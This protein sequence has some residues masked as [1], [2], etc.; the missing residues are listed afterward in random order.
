MS[1][2]FTSLLRLP[3]DI[4]LTRGLQFVEL[5]GSAL[6]RI[7]DD[8]LDVTQPDPTEMKNVEGEQTQRLGSSTS[9]TNL[10]NIYALF[11]VFLIVMVFVGMRT[12]RMS[13]AAVEK[14]IT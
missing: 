12:K 6:P 7:P 5:I 3:K 8:N 9:H 14:S 13:A 10:T 4:L 2:P 11:A 1:V